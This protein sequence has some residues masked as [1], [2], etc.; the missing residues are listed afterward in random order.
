[1]HQFWTDTSWRNGTK[2]RGFTGWLVLSLLS[3]AWVAEPTRLSAQT[4]AVIQGNITD[5]QGLVISGAEITLTGSPLPREIKIASDATGSYRIPGL[6]PGTYTLAV[7]KPGFAAKMF[8]AL[9]VTVNRLLIL[10]VVLAVSTKREV[11]S[12]SANA[13]LIDGSISSSG[14]TVLPQEIERMPINGRN[15]L[16]LMQLVPGVTVNRQAGPGTDAAAPILGERSGNA[17]FLIDGMPN[18]NVVDGGPAAP[19]DEDT[20]LEFQV[21]TGGYS[22]E[23]GHGSGG[24]VN[25]LTKSGTAQW[26]GLASAFHR[27]SAL[28]SS[29][30]SGKDAPF[31]LRWD[32][33]VNVGG[34]L[35]RDRVFALASLERIR[36]SRQL[37]F[38]FPANTPKFLQS[39]EEMFDKHNQTFETRGFLKF[40]EQ[41]ERHHLT[42][43][44]N[45]V[46]S[47]ATNFLPLS[48]A[49]NL[50]STRTDSDVRHLI[51]G[52][53]DTATLGSQSNPLL[54][55]AYLQ[56]RGEPFTERA[57]HPEASPATTLFNMFSSL[58]TGRLTGDLGQVEFGAGFTPLSV[59]PRYTST[60]AHFD[61]VV[62]K[63]D[64]K[65]G[66]DFEHTS[67]EGV[68]A[69]N[70]LNQL[71]ATTSDFAQFGPVNSGVYVLTKV[72]GLTSPDNSIR[73][74]NNYNGLFV[75][76]DWKIAR[77]LTLNLG[78][79]WDYDSRFPNHTNF[80]PRLGLAWSLT[81]ETILDASWG[82][83]YD[84]FRIGL[85]RDIPGFGGASLFSNETI[86]LPRLFYGDPSSL[87]QLFGLCA[88]PVLTDAQISASGAACPTPGL[89]FFGVDH[90]NKVVAS[91][92]GPIPVTTVV[93]Q[94]TVQTL[95][96]LSPT[97]F[98]DAASRAVN[99][100][101][102]F[103]FWGGFGNLTMNFPVPQIFQIPITVDR[104][105]KT[106]YTRGFHLGMQREI[107]NNVVFL[108]D[109]YHRDIRN[110][111]GVRTTNLAF[112]A[113][114]PGHTGEL[115]PGTG[116]RPILS[117][118]AWYQGRYDAVSIGVHKRMSKHFDVDAFYTW[119][120]AIDNAL[121]SSF[122]SEVQTGLGAGVLGAKGP[123]DSFVGVP[124]LV[125]DAVTGQT[126][127]NGQFIASNGNP[128]PQ[129]GKFYNGAN[130]DRG[131]SDL[132]LNHT[133]LM[134]GTVDLPRL[135]EI[136]GIFRAQSGFHFTDSPL[137]PADVD[138]D[139]L[140]NGV[141]FLVGRNHFQAPAYA[142]VDVRFSKRFMFKERVRVWTMLEFFNLLNRANP[143]AV[144]QF[145][146]VSS[147]PLGKPLQFLPGREGEVGLRIEF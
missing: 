110:M 124:P 109:Y 95:T 78:A 79:R 94:D 69:G 115:Q 40:D 129:A 13:P 137:V 146:N 22:A 62:N 59:R 35:I 70:L 87:L 34:P 85:A 134:H 39:R 96:G 2:Y 44:I 58:T 24:V 23:F 106:P 76:D 86:S 100:Q 91:G 92:H 108:A 50:P 36:E 48:E 147:T 135:F 54:I 98:A 123:T 12:V 29:D 5:A 25:V 88:S 80:S 116:S 143:A 107:T 46:N 118:G 112:E 77:D 84:N 7:A 26:H 4:T 105:F 66:W 31:L 139:G 38:S 145:Q 113:R 51:L 17:M 30:V 102:G 130:L 14:A 1:M 104:S 41:W 83:F 52:F 82:I 8:D 93:T 60:G 114:M 53:H 65:F 15:Y 90:L 128:V 63:H 21:V 97:Q 122:V 138:G 47:H 120:N 18:R 68:E 67:V 16:D 43:Q 72:A 127:K 89:P 125:T 126:N 117:Y 119:T 20:I 111:L 33:S 27:N 144:E 132:A 141:D 28:D 32:S 131:P 45:L 64:V 6:Q 73:L 3:F 10:D 101:P 56:Y 9:A 81:P 11:I 57:A 49:I 136:S 74:R 103:F 99:Q 140:R 37:N 19:F 55:S 133:F 121:Q 61:K 75:Q 71:F 142:N 42:E